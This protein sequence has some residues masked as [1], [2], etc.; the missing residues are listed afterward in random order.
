MTKILR[1]A[2]GLLLLLLLSPLRAGLISAEPRLTVSD[3]VLVR[4]VIDGDTIDVA[5]VGRVRL[6]GIDAPELGRP[7][8]SAAPFARQ[9]QEK[10]I[11]LVLHRWIR[12]QYEDDSLD[13]YDRRLAYVLLESGLHVNA[14]MVRAGLARVS[15][16]RAL[17]RIDELTR[18]EAEA[19]AWRRGMWSRSPSDAG[20]RYVVPRRRSGQGTPR[21]FGH[22]VI[23]CASGSSTCCAACRRNEPFLTRSS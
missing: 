6:L 18:A 12:L 20:E 19:K 16:R 21:I 2:I 11:S 5:S 15:T 22:E 17:S 14:E 8:E 4:R 23:H 9:A 10:L 1:N 3:S 13:A 7:P